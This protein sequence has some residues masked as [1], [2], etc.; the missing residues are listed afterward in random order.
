MS[1][2]DFTSCAAAVIVAGS[3]WQF[4]KWP[5]KDMAEIF[6]KMLAFHF[7][8]NDET[9]NQLVKDTSCTQLTFSREITRRHEVGVMM[10]Q[11]WKAMHRF[12]ELSK[13][14]ILV[15]PPK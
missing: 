15:K 1:T 13:P 7:R 6:T 9:R 4:D 12:L 10:V 11:F 2:S 3:S 14:H 8:Y 5:Y